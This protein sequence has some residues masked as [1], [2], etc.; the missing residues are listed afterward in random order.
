VKIDLSRPR[1]VWG[2]GYRKECRW[3][4]LFL[5]GEKK[6]INVIHE[7]PDEKL[8]KI[9]SYKSIG[10]ILQSYILNIH[11]KKRKENKQ[12][13]NF[14]F[15]RSYAISGKWKEKDGN[16]HR[17]TDAIFHNYRSYIEKK[18]YFVV[19]YSLMFSTYMEC[20]KRQCTTLL[21]SI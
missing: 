14:W 4:F 20:V 15:R 12:G 6:N 16:F 1:P 3:L 5:S 11:R 8:L 21:G 7:I 2:H 10:T 18:N 19:L 17:A 13:R 9:K